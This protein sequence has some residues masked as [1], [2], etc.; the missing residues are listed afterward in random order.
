ME[1]NPSKEVHYRG[2]RKRS[3]KYAAEIRDSF[4]ASARIWLGT[5]DTA[6]EAARAYDRAAFEMRG[7]LAVLNFPHEYRSASQSSFSAPSSSSLAT[8]TDPNSSMK[9]EN[10]VLELEYLDDNL[11]EEMLGSSKMEGREKSG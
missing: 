8:H 7:N 10:Q 1:Q 2:V 6:I 9:K 5:Y 11:L 3:G 4:N